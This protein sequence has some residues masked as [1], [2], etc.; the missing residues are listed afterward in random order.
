MTR[1]QVIAAA[2]RANYTLIQTSSHVLPIE[3]WSPYGATDDDERT[4][5]GV[6]LAWDFLLDA[7]GGGPRIVDVVPH[8]EIAGI[9]WLGPRPLLTHPF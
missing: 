1:A 9:W 6:P 2:K 8:G 7:S 3:D 4:F 5:R